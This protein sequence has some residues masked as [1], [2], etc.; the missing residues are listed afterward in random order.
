MSEPF[1]SMDLAS[2]G[3][4]EWRRQTMEVNCPRF[5]ESPTNIIRF[6]RSFS[7]INVALNLQSLSLTIE[8]IYYDKKMNQLEI[9]QRKQMYSCIYLGRSQLSGC[10]L[11]C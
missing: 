7:S 10:H 1:V 6:P 9:H 8:I 5:K 2:G 11:H 3:M 4:I